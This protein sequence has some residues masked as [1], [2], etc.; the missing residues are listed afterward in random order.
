[1]PETVT[2]YR[3]FVAS[4]S[5]LNDERQAISEVITELNLGYGEQNNIVLELVKWETH[6]AP[7]IS[8][9]HSQDIVNNDIDDNYD[10]FIGLMWMKFGTQTKL[11]GSGTEEEY[12]KAYNKFNDNPNSLQILFYFKTMPPLSL[13]DIDISELGKVNDFKKS[14]GE[15]NVLYWNFNSVEELQGY[16]RLHVPKRLSNLTVDVNV[17]TITKTEDSVDAI[18]VQE[19]LGYLD[20]LELAETKFEISTK[21]LQN[22]TDATEWI[23]E[24]MVEKTDELNKF[25][26]A[27]NSHFAPNINQLKK[28]FR[29]TGQAMT[30][31]ASRLCVEIPIYYDNYEE[32]IKAYSGIVNIADDF[33]TNEN[34]EDLIEAKESIVFLVTQINQA[35]EQTEEYYRAVI[36]LPRIDQE[37]NKAKRIVSEQLKVLMSN[38]KTSSQLGFELINEMSEKIN[39]IEITFANTSS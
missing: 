26:K 7:G 32:G 31:Y 10:L 23:G 28:I 21:A 8:Q 13:E 35:L 1:M 27:S 20:Y 11:A 24:K 34:I 16:L 36:E 19:E 25:N 14:L 3:V 33:F 2:K 38:M 4:P 5:D 9:S 37:I 39:R 29:L 18:I 15:E 17:A 30:E 12:R 6:S 22:I